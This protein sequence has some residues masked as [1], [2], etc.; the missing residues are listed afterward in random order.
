MMQIITALKALFIA[1][2]WDINAISFVKKRMKFKFFLKMFIGS[3]GNISDINKTQFQSLTVYS[4]LESSLF[5]KIYMW[6]ENGQ[7]NRLFVL[8]LQA[9]RILFLFLRLFLNCYENILLNPTPTNLVYW[10]KF[11]Y[12]C[13]FNFRTKTYLFHSA[14][15]SKKYNNLLLILKYKLESHVLSVLCTHFFF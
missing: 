8:K 7:N 13:V 5:Y 2:Y 14:T 15:T 11:I 12:E 10:W 9:E 6:L 3:Y 1:E 4:F